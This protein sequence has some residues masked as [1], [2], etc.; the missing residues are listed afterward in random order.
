MF[1]R[2]GCCCGAGVEREA[3]TASSHCCHVESGLLLAVIREKQQPCWGCDFC[4]Y[5]RVVFV[6]LLL[7]NLSFAYY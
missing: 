3:T 7:V 1:F 5:A 6:L 2:G 4:Q